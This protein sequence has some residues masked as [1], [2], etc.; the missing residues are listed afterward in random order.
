MK[1]KKNHNKDC[2]NYFT[3]LK[4]IS[5]Q[6]LNNILINFN[7]DD[8][9]GITSKQAIINRKIYGNNTLF[10]DKKKTY[11]QTF[12]KF[13][14]N[15]FNLILFM[16]L[17]I[18][19]LTA[20]TDHK[21]DF[22]T[23][24]SIVFI[25]LFSNFINLF[26]EVKSSKILEKLKKLVQTTVQ[27]IRDNK[28]QEIFSDELVIGDIVLLKTGDIVSADMKLIDTKLFF[29]QEAHLTGEAYVVEKNAFSKN[30]YDNVFEDKR[31]LFMGTNVVSGDA[32]GIVISVGQNSYLGLVSK[33]INQ[34]KIASDFQNGIKSISKFLVICIFVVVPLI[35]FINI[36]KNQKNLSSSLLFSLTIAFGLTP[37][38]LPL[39]ITT[40]LTAGLFVLSK[41]KI[42]VKNLTSI[43]DFGAIN[44]LF[45]DKTGT[46]TEGYISVD[47]YLDLNYNLN[48][49][50]LE[51][52]YLNSFF[53]LNVKN[54]IDDAIID[55]F[56]NIKNTKLLY[57]NYKKKFI[58]IDE[59]P[60]NYERRKVSV[61]LENKDHHIRQMITKGAVEEILNICHYAEINEKIVILSDEDKKQI[62]T[63]V[64]GYN[65]KGFRVLGIST[66]NISFVND[67]KN[68]LSENQM[69]LVGFLTF[70][71]LIKKSAQKT[72]LSLKKYGVDIK[73]LTGD[74]ATLTSTVAEI[75]N[76]DNTSL[77]SGLDIDNL[78]DDNL[79]QKAKNISIFVKLSPEQKRRIVSV[80]QQKNNIVGFMG[81]GINDV[82]VMKKS[83]LSISVDSG[84]DITKEVADIIFLENDLSVV[85]TG[86][87]E[88]R[89]IY[90]NML[91]YLKFTLAS[92]F[93]NVLSVFT[94]SLFLD[95][96]PMQPIQILFLNLIY[97]VTC[98]FISLDNVDHKYIKKNCY[99]DLANI[100]VFMFFFGFISFVCDLLFFSI[101]RFYFG[102]Y[103]PEI[104][105][106]SWFI[107]SMWTQV[108]MIYLLRTD[109]I[110]KG[111]KPC[112]FMVFSSLIGIIIVTLAPII[113]FLSKFLLLVNIFDLDLS[114]FLWLVSI[115]IFYLILV[116]ISKK[117]FIFKYKK[118][119]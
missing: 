73:I 72:I 109:N 89:R 95:F 92:N 63:Q 98:I 96:I 87:I 71:D 65:R 40:S 34:Q 47:S 90:T 19:L 41:N 7:T 52:A 88:G 30:I 111:S 99:W 81:D 50:V 13:F 83:N 60:F 76:I 110:V 75:I 51:Y 18:S 39:I 48:V 36:F 37:E 66:K 74:N 93:G 42:F 115:L 12:F 105:Q 91:K 69:I 80:F 38:M 104:F 20:F 108:L 64:N 116:I 56:E 8:Q 29:V 46:L 94:A 78:D 82:A 2:I 103:S 101:F 79:Y 35:F 112:L 4:E 17:L 25:F 100:K 24:I 77:L 27:V 118:L 23:I 3:F 106:T 6:N 21:S 5:N 114:V 85:K 49:K 62:L 119:L 102:N 43:Q 58:K 15:P 113:P 28:I 67:N 10:S 70:F 61:V 45:T 59:I 86:I 26:Q 16:M 31:L 33:N 9:F 84:A 22:T 97:D 14:L 117:F 54:I 68:L 55:K 44:I 53:S 57:T 1:N 107:F 11:L 32:K